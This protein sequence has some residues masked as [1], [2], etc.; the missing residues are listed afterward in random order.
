M[1]VD[2][3]EVQLD[4]GLLVSGEGRLPAGHRARL[5]DQPALGGGSARAAA[6]RCGD[7]A[8]SSTGAVW[9]RVAYGG[10]A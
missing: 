5:R 6:K 7:G 9:V 1:S 10:I 4:Q 2:F 3:A 8:G